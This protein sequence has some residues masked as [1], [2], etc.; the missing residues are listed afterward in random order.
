MRYASFS[1]TKPFVGLKGT[2]PW[3]KTNVF[4]LTEEPVFPR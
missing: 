4:F 3:F 1:I 2:P